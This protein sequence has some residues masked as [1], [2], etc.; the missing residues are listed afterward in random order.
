MAFEYSPDLVT[1]IAERCTQ[2][3]T[4]ARNI[5]YIIERTILP[6]I[7]VALLEQLAE[8][9]K[10]NQLVLELDDVGEFQYRFA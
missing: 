3:D 10:P 1:R 6:G 2:V 7:S 4:G 8:E 9:T 5:D